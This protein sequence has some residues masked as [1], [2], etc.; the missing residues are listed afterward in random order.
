MIG[1]RRDRAVEAGPGCGLRYRDRPRRDGM[2]AERSSVM[3]EP[4]RPIQPLFDLYV[5]GPNCVVN[6]IEL[7]LMHNGEVLPQA[8]GGLET[9]APIQLVGWWYR[10]MQ[11]G[12]PCRC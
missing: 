8:P 12:G 1:F 4:D 6:L 3:R 2:K 5:C 9:Q 7:P 11:V 10:S